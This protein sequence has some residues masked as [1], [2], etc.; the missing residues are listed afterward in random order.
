MFM[1]LREREK[2]GGD[3]SRSSVYDD[4]EREDNYR[5]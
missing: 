2:G 4:D 3:N 1:I 5:S